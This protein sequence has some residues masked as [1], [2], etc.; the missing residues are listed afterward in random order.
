MIG[1][2]RTGK[3]TTLNDG[4]RDADPFIR[5]PFTHATDERAV[6]RPHARRWVLLGL[7]VALCIAWLCVAATQSRGPAKRLPLGFFAGQL[8]FRPATGSETGP[9]SMAMVDLSTGACR[10]L[11][12]HPSGDVL[13]SPSGDWAFVDITTPERQRQVVVTPQS[14]EDVPT[15]PLSK[16]VRL[17]PF[18]LHKEGYVGWGGRSS[19]TTRPRQGSTHLVVAELRKGCVQTMPWPHGLP[20]HLAF[21]REPWVLYAGDGRG[22]LRR[23]DIQNR[24]SSHVAEGHGS[25]VS[26]QGWVA[27]LNPDKRSISIRGYTGTSSL[28]YAGCG[29]KISDLT[30]APNGAALAYRYRLGL[31]GIV[32]GK[33]DEYGVGVLDLATGAHWRVLSRS[34]DIRHW[35]EAASGVGHIIW[36][37]QVSPQLL[38]QLTRI[39]GMEGP[40]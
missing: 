23:V 8:V 27:Y 18:V 13:L 17:T 26:P 21:G 12:T 25:V 15:L 3:S 7:V 36:A 11:P 9:P 16:Y 24:S 20:H 19:P 2:T 34:D 40:R 29:V 28:S 30:W 31:L 38:E 6:R 22:G 33:R 32:S 14:V 5:E 4:R 37:M 39:E 1:T 10:S 35:P